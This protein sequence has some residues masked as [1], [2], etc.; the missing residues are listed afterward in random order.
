MIEM[1][2][3]VNEKKLLFDS[4]KEAVGKKVVKRNFIKGAFSNKGYLKK[5][6]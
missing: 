5:I 2:K 3:K 6:R 1:Q 4:N